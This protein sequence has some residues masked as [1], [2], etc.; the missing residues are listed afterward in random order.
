MSKGLKPLIIG[1]LEIKVPII[2][3]GMGVRVSIASLASAVANCGAGGTIAS[4][5][6][7]PDTPENRQDI[8]K[9]CREHLQIQIR[10]AREMTQGALGV[11]IMVALS[12]YEDMVRTAAA[13][14]IDYIISGAGVPISLP[15]FAEGSKVKLIPLIASGRAAALLLKTW[16]RRYDRLPDAL[17][18]EGP[19]SGGHIA[20]YS[21][22]ELN[23]LRSTMKEKPLLENSVKEV[24]ALVNEYEKEYGVSIP[25]IAAGGIF[26]GRDVAKFFRLGAK[27]VQIGTRFI[28]TYE[29]DAAKEYKDLYVKAKEEDLVY[30][31]SPVGMPAKV[32]R[33]K[34]LDD[35]LRGEKKEFDCNYQCLR[36]CDPATVQY[37]IAKALIDAVEGR[38][39]KAVVFAGTYIS[40]ID[41]IVSVKEL[42]DEIVSEAEE[43]LNK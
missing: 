33:T 13:E 11:N 30:I 28:A 21:L 38:I 29:C 14:D 1:D 9:A 23:E 12:N 6:L 17:V 5:G 42:I 27:G 31:Q 22:K 15:E 10:R 34:F 39:D 3:G 2:Q 16:K 43:E 37:C 19:L 7:P 32:I 24:I 26:D 18:V 4:V 40:R 36:T 8:P 35:V 20:G 41:K 25:V